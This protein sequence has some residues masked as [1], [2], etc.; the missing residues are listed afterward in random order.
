MSPL[1]FT[2]DKG[3]APDHYTAPGLWPHAGG[4]GRLDGLTPCL[5]LTLFRDPSSDI[6]I[7]KRARDT[8]REAEGRSATAMATH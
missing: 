2:L 3:Y 1:R 7:Y 4:A 6:T 8:T 5:G